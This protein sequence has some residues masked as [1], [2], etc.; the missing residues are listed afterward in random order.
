MA[1]LKMLLSGSLT[2]IITT[3]L[4][5]AILIT[6]SLPKYYPNRY[7][8]KLKTYINSN[9][10]YGESNITMFFREPTQ[11]ISLYAEG[12][13]II[14]IILI[15]SLEGIDKDAKKIKIIESNYTYDKDT[16]IIDLYSMEVLLKECIINVRFAGALHDNRGIRT[17]YKR[18]KN[19]AYE[20]WLPAIC[21]LKADT[22]EM[23]PCW[24]D[25]RL[26]SK[27]KISIMHRKNYEILSNM[28]KHEEEANEKGML[29]THFDTTPEMY[30]YLLAV[31][32]ASKS[33]FHELY[34]IDYITLWGRP[35]YLSDLWYAQRVMGNVTTFIHNIKWKRLRE[36]QKLDNIAIP[37]Y[38]DYDTSS[39]GLIF[40]RESDIL[41]NKD[42]DPAGRKIEVARLI[43]YKISQ[44]WLPHFHMFCSLSPWVQKTLATFMGTYAV[45]KVFPETRMMD[46]FVVQI[47]HE[48][49]F[50]DGYF[51]SQTP[52]SEAIS[53][54]KGSV[55]LRMLQHAFTE[56]SFWNHII[57][58]MELCIFE[59]TL[60]TAYINEQKWD[61]LVPTQE[62]FDVISSNAEQLKSWLNHKRYPI[63]KVMRIY[64]PMTLTVER[65]IIEINSATKNLSIPL[66]YTTQMQP[67]FYNTTPN[68]W[69]IYKESHEIP[70]TKQFIQEV[71]NLESNQWIIFNLQQT[72][73]YRVN[74][75]N[76]NWK[77]ISNYLKSENYVNIHVLNRAQIIDDAFHLMLAY[78]ISAFRFWDIA[79]YLKQ[80]TDYVAW[81][82]MFK[83]LEYMSR[84]FSMDLFGRKLSVKVLMRTILNELLKK[85]YYT[86]VSNEDE[87]KK[88]L[89]QEAA[90]WACLLDVK[91]C[92]KEANNKLSLYLAHPNNHKILP[93]WKK[94]TYCNGLSSF[95]EN[96]TLQNINFEFSNCVQDIDFIKYYLRNMKNILMDS[97][98]KTYNL[99]LQTV[100]SYFTLIT[101]Q[102]KIN[103]VREFILSNFE[104][105]ISRQVNTIAT[106]TVI[107]NNLY[108][109]KQLTE[110][111][112]FVKKDMKRDRL[113]FPHCPA[114]CQIYEEATIL[115]MQRK[116]E[117]RRL[118]IQY[119]HSFLETFLYE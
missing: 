35:N 3:T 51:E 105:V 49:L 37:D 79:D 2:F 117:K 25:V 64:Q 87:H 7:D 99:R 118:Q 96:Y 73:Y 100:N 68:N 110:L 8:I 75:D 43:G 74:Y 60:Q 6:N 40:Y 59:S 70:F 71:K 61:S 24:D 53:Y 50:W 55:I 13:C 19:I 101:K 10:F 34:T 14:D 26:A 16:H 108:T 113:V 22:Q 69:L 33:I 36:I 11:E 66:T 17:F 15:Q 54:L 58:G 90:K 95:K 44:E 111:E 106:L 30:I 18:R 38:Q 76:E 1:C 42:A 98:S 28:P 112:N 114:M 116:I 94:W 45:D 31:V 115:K 65:V 109:D 32:M 107:I 72:G 48:V 88:C 78:Q 56:E 62:Q 86:E 103:I 82:P 91:E 102:I 93:W 4:V 81:Y 63:I 52:F 84:I 85:I 47:Q 20:K 77:R 21:L 29:W 97:S 83:A 89:R 46:L 80:E 104:E 23:F 39:T 92:K 9:K 41:Y 57:W 12:L 67:N 5:T 119:L 27:F